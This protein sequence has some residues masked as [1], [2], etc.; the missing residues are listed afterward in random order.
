MIRLM[1]ALMALGFSFQANAGA[2]DLSFACMNPQKTRLV[3]IA[4]RIGFDDATLYLT[5]YG[6]GEDNGSLLD[7]GLIHSYAQVMPSDFSDRAV[8]S[9]NQLK[10]DHK[11]RWVENQVVSAV[12][13][14]ADANQTVAQSLSIQY[15]DGSTETFTQCAKDLPPL[16]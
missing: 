9:L 15:Q 3:E 4:H 8:I 16:F 11:G 1:V 14:R 6:D 10:T 12:L 2:K 13:N 7:L 5:V